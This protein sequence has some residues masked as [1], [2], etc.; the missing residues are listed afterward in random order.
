MV[1]ARAPGRTCGPDG[2]AVGFPVPSGLSTSAALEFSTSTDATP[3]GHAERDVVAAAG[4]DLDRL[5]RRNPSRCD[6]CAVDRD[7]G[8]EHPGELELRR[9]AVGVDQPQTNGRAR[10]HRLA[11]G[12]VMGADRRATRERVH[13]EG[14][15]ETARALLR[16]DDER[17][18]EPLLHALGGVL[19]RV[20]PE[21]PDLLRA[22][23]V[24]VAAA[25]LDGVLGDSG[26]AVFGVRDVEAVPVDRHAVAD[27]L[28][29]ERDLDEV[30]LTDAKLRAGR[31]AVERPGVHLLARGE[32]HRSLL[33]RSA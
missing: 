25:R 12:V 23:A 28:V 10:S 29:D 16:I 24:D 31:A 27:V 2:A 21:R 11:P 17:A 5:A 3:L 14:E 20:V 13:R 26:D 1:R 15:V 6:L 18:E 7:H 22:E 9:C 19:M 32:P 8:R 4:S 33:A 30:A